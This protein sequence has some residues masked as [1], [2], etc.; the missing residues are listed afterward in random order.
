MP[1]HPVPHNLRFLLLLAA[2][3]VILLSVDYLGAFAGVDTYFYDTFLR[4]RGTRPTSNRI[5]IIAVDAKTLDRF[6]QWPIKRRHYAEML[7][8]LDLAA[9]VGFDLLL[10]EP[11][12]DDGL[13]EAAI[14]RHGRVV[15]PV[16]VGAAAQSIGP[17]DRFSSAATG[18]IHIELGVDNTARELF[19]SVYAN[20]L[21]PSLS[22]KMYETVSGQPFLRLSPPVPTAGRL[23]QQNQH[24]INYYGTPGTFT[25]ISLAD[26][27]DGTVQPVYFKDKL[28]LVG[29]TV[30]GI[31]DEVSTPLSQTRNRMPGVE[32]HANA[33]N[34]LLDKSSIHE[35]PGFLRAFAAL[36]TALLLAVVLARRD[37]KQAVLIWGLSLFL[38]LLTAFILLAGTHW[39]VPPT[40]FL[41][42]FSVIFAAVYL[43]RLDSAA[44]KLDHE[45]EIM[46]ALLGRDANEAPEQV[47]GSGL[48]GFLSEGGINAKIGRQVSMTNKLLGLHKQLESALKTER[49]A[50]DNQIRFVEM[51]SHEY[52][53]PLAIIRANLDILEMKDEDLGGQLS[54]NFSKMKRAVSRL[55]EVMET[56]LGRQRLEEAKAV[57]PANEEIDLTAFLDSLLEESGELW[58]ERSFE[59]YGGGCSGCCVHGDRLMLKTAVL[60]LIDNAVKY[61]AVQEPVRVFLEK[62][63]GQAILSVVNHGVPVAQEELERVFEKFYRGGSSTNTRG[64]GLGLYLVRKIIEQLGGQVTLASD[65]VQVTTTAT[66]NLPLYR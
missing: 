5:V 47:A 29:L 10:R 58:A 32:V 38:V 54:G 20:E 30:P 52:R 15:L 24:T 60:N 41:V 13:L 28:V 51:L 18:H 40:F 14:K 39:W 1:T 34:N 7:D 63:D 61:S 43:Y 49:E 59:R 36:L 2:T 22:S 37:E 25:R 12:A 26:L 16:Y 9:V 17:L 3:L 56:S 35:L 57:L 23:I 31:L 8:R 42:A 21:L 33:L 19:H 66:I 48:F 55:V 4:L 64:A 11:T 46:T 53:T 44:R 27:L 45:Y 65:P 50:L 6:G 62:R